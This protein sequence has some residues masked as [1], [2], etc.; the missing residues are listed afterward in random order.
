SEE[1]FNYFLKENPV[2][3]RGN[4]SRNTAETVFTLLERSSAENGSLVKKNRYIDYC[5]SVERNADTSVIDLT[6]TKAF[7][8][9]AFVVQDFSSVLVGYIADRAFIKINGENKNG[10][11]GRVLDLCAAPG[12]KSMHLADLG[13][14]VTSCDISEAKL[15]LIREAAAR[16]GFDRVKVLENDASEY[17]KDFE[18]AYDIVICDLPCSGLGIIGKKPDIKYNMTSEKSM[19]LAELQRK[20]LENAVRYVVNGGILIFSTCTLRTCENSDNV[21]FIKNLPKT[22]GIPIAGLLP[23]GMEAGKE[24]C[25][26]QILP[27]EYGSD[28]FWISCFWK[29]A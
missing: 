17:N 7:K 24:D 29:K 27:G 19:E 8:E 15:K 18:D 6:G 20:I 23:E 22:G 1:I 3:V 2:S 11:K 10:I 5:F 4:I 16:C 28:G 9:G 26:V 25:F 12:G 14:E 13:Y 21:S